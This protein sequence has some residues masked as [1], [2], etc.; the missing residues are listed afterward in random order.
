M[1]L[2]AIVA[3]WQAIGALDLSDTDDAM[4]MAQVRDLLH[5]VNGLELPEGHSFRTVTA[6]PMSAASAA[7]RREETTSVFGVAGADA[8]VAREG[9]QAQ[10]G[11]AVAQLA[12]QRTARAVFLGHHL[13]HRAADA[14][15]EGFGLHAARGV[16]RQAQ[17]EV[18]AQGFGGDA[19]P[20]RE[21][22]LQVG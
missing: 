15:A 7:A 18:A 11:G 20:R 2:V 4:R 5:W 17:R 1:S 19:R 10:V 14:A 16:R 12:L 9:F 6:H 22:Q 13:A 8:D 21:R 3:K